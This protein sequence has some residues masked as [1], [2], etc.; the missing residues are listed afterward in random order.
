[1]VNRANPAFDSLLVA[2]AAP[3]A[4]R[5]TGPCPALAVVPTPMLVRTVSDSILVRVPVDGC[6]FPQD[7][8]QQ[9][10]NRA[11]AAAG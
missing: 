8:V 1:M 3:D 9:A 10:I 7:A 11:R 4:P 6:G 2:L 5:S